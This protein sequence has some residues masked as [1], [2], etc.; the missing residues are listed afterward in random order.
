[1]LKWWAIINCVKENLW[2]ARNIW[3]R[4]GYSVPDIKSVV[5]RVKDYILKEKSNLNYE[6]KLEKW[7]IPH[8][9]M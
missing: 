7:K 6:Q 9:Y 3:V 5:S 8:R 2:K 1:M 4:K